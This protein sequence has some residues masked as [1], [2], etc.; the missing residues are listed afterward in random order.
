MAALLSL[1]VSS[2]IPRA[3]LFS[4]SVGLPLAPAIRIACAVRDIV[5]VEGS[6]VMAVRWTVGIFFWWWHRC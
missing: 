4:P 3:L 6:V 2:V 5:V 1:P